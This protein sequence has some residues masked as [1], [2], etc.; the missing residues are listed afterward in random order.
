MARQAREGSAGKAVGEKKTVKYPEIVELLTAL[1]EKHKAGSPT[2]DNV[3]WVSV[4]P[5]Q[6]AELFYEEHQIRV[7]HGLVKRLLKDL[8]VW[9]SQTV[10]TVIHR[11]LWT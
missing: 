10:Q 7:S 4:K 2:E 11:R 6:L 5:W 3:Y 8:G 1:I 9:V